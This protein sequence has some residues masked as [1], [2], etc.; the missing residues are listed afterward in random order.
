MLCVHSLFHPIIFYAFVPLGFS[1]ISPSFTFPLS[2][3]AVSFASPSVLHHIWFICR[4][5]QFPS[6]LFLL[7]TFSPSLFMKGLWS[8]QERHISGVT[9][10]RDC[11][12]LAQW[13]QSNFFLLADD[14]EQC[15]TWCSVSSFPMHSCKHFPPKTPSVCPWLYFLPSL[16]FL[17][18]PNNYRQCLCQRRFHKMRCQSLLH[19]RS[20]SD[21]TRLTT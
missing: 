1:F 16:H 18:S 9:D 17:N 13:C 10:G 12:T 21:E 15:N 4:F 2:L 8:R 6:L 3:F 7:A 20:W 5:W 14:W 19:Q 11:R